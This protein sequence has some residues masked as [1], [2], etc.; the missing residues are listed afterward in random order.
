MGAYTISYPIPNNW[1]KN[2]VRLPLQEQP[3]IWVQITVPNE[4]QSVGKYNIGVTAG[5]EGDIA[6][7]E[8]IECI[9]RMQLIIVPFY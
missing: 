2:I 8:W 7:A 9:N 5:T 3:D 1:A 4:F 6:P